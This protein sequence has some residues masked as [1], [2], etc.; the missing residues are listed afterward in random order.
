MNAKDN[1]RWGTIIEIK[2]AHV[3]AFSS[4]IEF[5]PSWRCCSHTVLIS[6]FSTYFNDLKTNYECQDIDFHHLSIPDDQEIISCTMKKLVRK[7]KWSVIVNEES[8]N[9]HCMWVKL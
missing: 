4:S 6:F 2:V 3:A 9:M 8:N 7:V 1:G 5:H